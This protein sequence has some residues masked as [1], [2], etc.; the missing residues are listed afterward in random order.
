MRYK[1]KYIH[2]LLPLIFFLVT[3][4]V[5]AQ[6]P[7]GVSTGSTRGY[8]VDYYNGTFNNQT[9]FGV[10]TANATP[11]NTAYSNKIT[12][13]EFFPIDQDY[14][15]LEYSGK[16]EITVAGSYTFNL[17][18]D[19]RIWLYIDG[20]LIVQAAYP[21][22]ASG[23]VSLS[24]GDHTIKV[25]MYELAGANFATVKFGA[26]PAGIAVG[27]DVDGRF[28]R[29][30]NSK[31]TAWYKGS[32]LTVT[33]NFGGTGIDKVNS[34]INMAPDYAGIGNLNYS[35]TGTAQRETATLVNF[36]S[37]VRFSGDDDFNSDS[38]VNG[39]SLRGATKS[40]FLVNNYTSN[41]SQT[42]VWMFFHGDNTNNQRIGFFKENNTNTK[43]DV[44][45]NGVSGIASNYTIGEPKLLGGF[46]N[47]ALG[48]TA[49]NGTN[50][51]NMNINGN[52]GTTASF[53]SNADYDSNGLYLANMSGAN[54]PEAI[55][56]PFAL[57]QLQERKVNTYLAIKYGVTLSHDYINTSGTVVFDV[58]GTTN[59]GYK[60]R[61]FGI[62]KELTA[63][64]LNQKQSQSQNVAPA[65]TSGYDFLVASKGNITTTNSSNT[66]VLADG[67][68]LIVGDNGAGF[69]S[70]TTELSPSISSTC[71]FNRMAR[72]WKVQIT[73]N[74]GSLTYR[75]GSSTTGSYTFSSGS[76]GIVMIVDTDGDGDFSNA[77]TTYAA[78]S[79]VNGVA[80]FENIN[81]ANGNVFT[82]GWTAISPGGVSVGLK[83]WTKAD[84]TSLAAGT[85]SQWND[86]SSNSNNLTGTGN[87][88]KVE[89]QF[90]YN[91]SVRFVGTADNTFLQSN[92]SLGMT[93]TNT[94]GEFYLLR[95]TFT[96]GLAFD[97]IITLGGGNHRWEN[98]NTGLNSG[99]YGVYGVGTAQG[100]TTSPPLM[101]NL[102]LYSNNATGTQALLRTNGVVRS[103]NNTTTGL[104]LSG[105]FRIGTDV[106][107]G[108]GNY[109]GFYVPEL[110][111]YNTNLT[112]TE[113][114]KIN[115]YLGIKYGIPL[116]DGLGTSASNYLAG[117]GTIIWTGNAVYK[118]GMFGIGRDDCSGL[119]QK[120]SKTYIDGTDNVAFGLSKLATTNANNT[121]TFATN[122]QF[123]IVA[124][125]GGSFVGTSTNI[126][127]NYLAQSCNA[128]RYTRNW[129]AQNTNNTN[130]ALQVT[131]G[132]ATN[133]MASNWSNVTLAINSAGDAT[134]A[135]GTTTLVI[136][137]SITLG[138]ATFD[139]V[140]LP[141]GAVF[142]VCYTLG[143][144]GGISKQK[145]ITIAAPISGNSTD[146]ANGLSY[147]LYTTNS[148]S[149]SIAAGFGA[150]SPVLY[151]TGYYNN[152][153][154]FN[155]FGSLNFTT[156]Y[157]VELTG[158][159]YVPT[160]ST[161]YQFR[162][163]GD[164]AIAVIIDGTTVINV[165]SSSTGFSGNINLSAGYHDIIVRGR[166]LSGGQQFDL[167]WNGGFG[168]SYVTIPDANFFTQ[169]T[170]PAGWYMADD[171]NFDILADG[172]ALNSASSNTWYDL[173]GNAN[174]VVTLTG[175]N[176][177]YYKTTATKIRNYNPVIE[178]AND[179]MQM[180]N[181]L[182]GFAFGRQGKSVFGLSNMSAG[183]IDEH[184]TGYGADDSA[185]D[186]LL[187]KNSTN[188]T[189]SLRGF[190][191]DL[192]ST[193]IYT[194]TP[195][196][197]I[198]NGIYK[199]VNITNLN[200]VSLSVDGSLN[201]QATR[202]LWNTAMENSAS[203]LEIG[204]AP[205][206]ISATGWD[207]RYSE[208]IYYPWSL[209]PL[210]K[211]K[212]D[213]YLAAKWGLTLNQTAPTNYLDSDGNVFWNAT[214]GIG[215]IK[216][217]T[218]IGRDDC[219]ALNQKQ[220]TSLDDKDIVA[221][222]KG[223]I[224]INNKENTS[225]FS[226]NK[227][228]LTWSNN[229]AAIKS[230][231]SNLLP[232]SLSATS[233]YV[234]IDRIWQTQ[235]VGNPGVV[236]V[237]MGAN[238]ILSINRSTY[239][240]VLLISTSAT[241][242]SNATVVTYSS[243]AQ[244]KA[245]FKN[246]DFGTDTV[247]YFTLGYINAAPGGEI[248]NLTAWYDAGADVF[249]DDNLSEYAQNDGDLVAGIS[250][251][252]FG[253]TL[254]SLV[255]SA[256][257]LKPVYNAS[258]F[259]YNPALIFDGNNDGLFTTSNTISSN[260]Y[261]TT[262]TMTSIVAASNSGSTANNQ[263]VLWMHINNGGNGKN[264][265][266]LNQGY[267][268][269]NAA[270][271]PRSPSVSLP[272]IYSMRYTTGT[273]WNLYKNL[274]SVG[275]GVSAVS[276]T[277]S[278]PFTIGSY[279][280]S[281]TGGSAFA[282]KFDM[283]EI[284]IYSDD[285]GLASSSAMRKMH[286]YLAL[287]YGYT[288]DQTQ[289]NGKYYAS[290]WNG[291]SGTITYNYATHWNRITGI[292]MDD[293]TALEQ[294]QSFSQETGAMVKLSVD[295]NGLA[296]SNAANPSTFAS[297]LTFLVFGDDNAS[298]SWT[299]QD[300]I[301]N[302]S[303]NYL[304]LERT[305][306]VKETGT[307]GTVYLETPDNSSSLTSKLPVENT[308]VYLI[309]SDSNDFSTPTAIVE[310]VLNGTDWSVNYDFATGDYFTFATKSSC[311]APGGIS[312]GLTSWYK[313][314]SQ[315]LGANLTLTDNSSNGFTLTRNGTAANIISGTATI[316][317][318]NRYL[319]GN[320]SVFYES[321][322]LTETSVYSVNAG[323]TFGVA[324]GTAK[325][326][327]GFG[328]IAT[329]PFNRT[330]LG[331]TSS[332][333]NDATNNYPVSTNVPNILVAN[334]SAGV[335]ATTKNHTSWNN[336][337]AGST[338]S[339][340]ANNLPAGSAYKLRFA[341]MTPTTAGNLANY[342]LAEAFTFN[343]SL[344]TVEVQKI[345]TYLA[346]KY[347]QTL[348]HNYFAPG[349]D[350]TNTAS[351]TLYDISTY[352]NRVFGVGFHIAGCLAQN[353]STSP[354]SG[355]LL[356]ISVDGS[357]LTE[358]S[359]DITP[360]NNQDRTYTIIGD[361]N[362]SLN[363]V[364]TNKPKIEANNT[365]L[366]RITRQWKV[367]STKLNPSLFI[368][369]PD[370]TNTTATTKLNLVPANNDVY[371]VISDQEDFTSVSA[372][373]Q[374]IKM[375]LNAVSKEWEAT[376]VFDANTTRYITFVYKTL[377]CGLPCVPVNPATSRIRLK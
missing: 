255:Q 241:D 219:G 193:F 74:P 228:F 155:T 64:G 320:N 360:W 180:N 253:A 16:L 369:I 44:A 132:D 36:N 227:S 183:A 54:I 55:Y 270:S 300:A 325:D 39:L 140:S 277:T 252:A 189:L 349:Y 179:R 7:G 273:S 125:D 297:N 312:N 124:N 340:T 161:T 77:T 337:L 208:I 116:G 223:T 184:L 310:M 188:N 237:E 299:D 254:P 109:N 107:G 145:G 333:F 267:F 260:T 99:S 101:G 236:N 282:G 352:G 258:K 17:T 57:S 38:S 86:L 328:Q 146:N 153:S 127:A 165:S 15:G 19:D 174:N 29:S 256:A 150:Y 82:F 266:E 169:I 111:V 279:K 201:I 304:R 143:F 119:V 306:R 40:M 240:P 118:N 67:D 71:G 370:S 91:P 205:G 284:I 197:N 60:N 271:L 43:F 301:V 202:P 170:G 371:M 160:A 178:F 368:T 323:T 231:N 286:S 148:S 287:K 69:T 250:N 90:N 355:S 249:T 244:G 207:G 229:G 305:W 238:G 232:V 173:S 46:V 75:A 361:N 137:S 26:N 18:G 224:M 62:G 156:N 182:T 314:N 175:D 199:N 120:Q 365:C 214:T 181:G 309:V 200:N 47:Q 2:L 58:S 139:N 195:T 276:G 269:N 376:G 176:P 171:N 321:T 285:K 12:G 377:T 113:I 154:N 72:E 61:I 70:Q 303:E 78:T 366:S 204:N 318:Y 168:G 104:S 142:T 121:G 358:N 348:A 93:G 234:K 106:D 213:S 84:D 239:K 102:G 278:G 32:D 356:K 56:Y 28:V 372:T 53:F 103:T 83:L 280:T 354:L 41:V 242:F 272:E 322:P 144:P 81:L 222:G 59:T 344:S 316:F 73:G 343:R 191:S 152:T 22:S 110:I 24:L 95:G 359:Q 198:L 288:L 133:K 112:A 268:Q 33:E 25:K 151:S 23:S 94:Y 218:V 1:L 136:A 313:L 68:Y 235:S 251:V 159:L 172:T 66:G 87:I 245:L 311:L 220:S 5:A 327:I 332:Y 375:T 31:L 158:K 339:L 108:D 186:F 92:N 34:F 225:S 243:I 30:D 117:D 331:G 166:Q 97:E 13:T 230:V 48:G 329:S 308:S 296:S 248:A 50:P 374:M 123:I 221:M 37:A 27:D 187:F 341:S 185:T 257:G 346:V 157:G 129:K 351:E 307:V 177:T 21:T 141:D 261:R 149:G 196:T 135:T 283:G 134:F 6:Y 126:P 293:C 353:Q 302:N 364:T 289:M 275:N 334:T 347:G 100:S 317:N 131:V 162:G 122:R 357:I 115:S 8:K 35:G 342:G 194:S 212:V 163:I 190:A 215:F 338:V 259:N 52:V 105:N 294:K 98:S 217:I 211:Q 263:F 233:C 14:Y 206:E 291:T 210:E 367:V 216:D 290:D 63:E 79:V 315:P 192:T 65:A 203:Q 167:T 246:V 114:Q 274:L 49:P 96:S 9:G 247:K 226:Y 89:N 335:L 88:I 336:G 264:G 373:Q 363:W 281:Y 20:N 147:K 292:G 298:L 319:P 45:N 4:N 164:D 11:S 51:L 262:T 10:G 85:I 362:G 42:S 76:A 130:N 265:Q 326:L 209:S 324:N 138:V 345:N 330:G 128:Y 350:G 80:T 295:P 3:I